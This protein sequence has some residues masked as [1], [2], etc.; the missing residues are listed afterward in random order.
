MSPQLGSFLLGSILIVTVAD[1]PEWK[2]R[3]YVAV[4][5]L[6]IVLAMA[7]G[8]QPKLARGFATM[9][10]AGLLIQRG[11]RLGAAIGTIVG[12]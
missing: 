11:E 1:A 4:L 2:L 3:P 7:E 12:K 10:F 9:V 6:G 5:T 8:T